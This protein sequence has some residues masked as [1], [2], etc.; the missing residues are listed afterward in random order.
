MQT[1][2]QFS[3]NFH[4]FFKMY[5]TIILN[6]VS[7]LRFHTTSNLKIFRNLSI[8]GKQFCHNQYTVLIVPVN[9]KSSQVCIKPLIWQ[10]FVADI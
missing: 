3:L 1:T 8:S 10:K 4:I 7:R 5:S 6:R 9:I 2:A